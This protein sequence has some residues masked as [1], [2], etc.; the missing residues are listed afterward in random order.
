MAE[1]WRDVAGKIVY[2]TLYLE[3]VKEDGREEHSASTNETK[4]IYVE[5]VLLSKKAGFT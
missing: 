5:R 2:R 1:E 4:G 3:R